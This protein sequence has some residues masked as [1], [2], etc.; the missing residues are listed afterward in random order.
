MVTCVS[1]LLRSTCSDT[2]SYQSPFPN[3][4]PPTNPLEVWVY[5][6]FRYVH[7]IYYLR[8]ILTLFVLVDVLLPWRWPS[9]IPSLSSLSTHTRLTSR[10]GQFIDFLHRQRIVV[11]DNVFSL[12]ETQNE[13]SQWVFFRLLKLKIRFREVKFT[14]I[15][16]KFFVKYST[17]F[18]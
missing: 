2:I 9:V 12:T 8:T 10:T 4:Y 18:I 14:I 1:F 17:G 16:K 11:V 6:R 5:R 7:Y 3:P 13:K 15:I